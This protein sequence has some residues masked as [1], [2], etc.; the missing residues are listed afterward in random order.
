MQ[1]RNF[2]CPAQAERNTN[3]SGEDFWLKFRISCGDSEDTR[4]GVGW[5]GGGSR[6]AR[7]RKGCGAEEGLVRRAGRDR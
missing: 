7:R 1:T 3:W 4:A 5:V 2:L 6:G